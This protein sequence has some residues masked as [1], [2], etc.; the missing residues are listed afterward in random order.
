MPVVA[1]LHPGRMGAAL[2]AQA[3]RSGTQVLWCSADRSAATSRR[4]EAA[5][6]TALPRLADVL[7]A[8]DIVMSVCPP[9]FAEDVA[10]DVAGHGYQGIFVEA[11]AISPQRCLR[12][13]ERLTQA[14]AT[15]VDGGIIGPPPRAGVAARLY[16][17][18][19]QRSLDVVAG[20]FHDSDV[21][22]VAVR[23]EVGAAS[24]LKMAFAG[25]NKISLVLSAVSH[26]LAA[27]HQVTEQLMAEAERL[28]P[29]PLAR[30]DSLPG[31]AASAW[32]WAPE[33]HE[34]ADALDAAG[35]P[36]DL[37]RAAASVLAHWQSDKDSW[38]LSVA[39][40]LARLDGP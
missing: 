33:M 18:G 30:P 25:Y 3:R 22:V 20:I 26:A 27:R 31:M 10:A 19:R 38:E 7:A 32:R 11:N 14:G 21:K 34:I 36:S 4:A 5:G 16:V 35:L 13:G 24:A 28:R 23:D 6:L 12:I 2:A 8:A 40:V 39:D 9:E 29:A 1:M 15:V 37:A 17:A